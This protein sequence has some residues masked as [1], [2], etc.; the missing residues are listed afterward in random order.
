M[1]ISGEYSSND[2]PSQRS[3]NLL[4]E[5]THSLSDTSV[6]IN[7]LHATI[8]IEVGSWKCLHIKR[9]YFQGTDYHT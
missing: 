3:S 4:L 2:A 8:I 6:E 1:F 7:F 5:G 9:E